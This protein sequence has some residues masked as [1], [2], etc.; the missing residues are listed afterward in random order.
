MTSNT[1]VIGVKLKLFDRSHFLFCH[2]EYTGESIR[3]KMSSIV[4]SGVQ[5]SLTDHEILWRQ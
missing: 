2:E 3:V 1:V 4:N 5:M